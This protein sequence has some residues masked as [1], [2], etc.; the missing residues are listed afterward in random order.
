MA[1]PAIPEQ[2]LQTLFEEHINNTWEV[3]SASE[4][5]RAGAIVFIELDSSGCNWDMPV[6]KGYAHRSKL[7][8][9]VIAELRTRYNV[10]KPEGPARQEA[11]VAPEISP[12]AV[13][14][15]GVLHRAKHGGPPPPGGMDTEYNE[16]LTFGLATFIGNRP[17]ITI[18]GE[19]ALREHFAGR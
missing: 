2:D 11:T 17:F 9:K 14:L 12:A 7:I 13:A 16:L 18:D 4:R 5:I 1:R 19:R 3:K 8:R 10:L 15:L 6:V